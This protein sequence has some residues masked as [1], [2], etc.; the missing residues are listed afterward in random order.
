MTAP[1]TMSTHTPGPFRLVHYEADEYPSHCKADARIIGADGLCYGI[2]FGGDDSYPD[3]GKIRK[4]HTLIAAAP[5]LLE[6][7]KNLLNEADTDYIDD[8]TRPMVEAAR[9]AIAKAEGRA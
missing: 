8:E 9:A 6:A 2:L 4:A 5:E 7:L 1:N 3:V